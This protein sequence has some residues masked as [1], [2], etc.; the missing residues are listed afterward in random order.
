MLGHNCVGTEHVLLGLLAEGGGVAAAALEGLKIGVEDVRPRVA[1]RVDRGQHPS[2]EPI[3]LTPHA[4]QVL[5]LS[6]V[7]A[8]QLGHDLIGTGHILLALIGEGDGGAVQVLL[9]QG[10]DLDQVREQVLRL[11][12]SPDAEA[13]DGG[14]SEPHS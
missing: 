5:E 12:A 14:P 3:P 10:A 9:H 4:R 6:S 11:L 13:E 1:G 8:R 2:P 7:E